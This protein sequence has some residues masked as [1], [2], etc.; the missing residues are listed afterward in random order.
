MEWGPAR[1]GISTAVLGHYSS[2]TYSSESGNL[3]LYCSEM[4]EL[5]ASIIAE[6]VVYR[7]AR[8]KEDE[9]IELPVQ[10]TPYWN[11]VY[12][13][14]FLPTPT[15]SAVCICLNSLVFHFAGSS[16]YLQLLQLCLL[17]RWN[18][19]NDDIRLCLCVYIYYM[20]LPLAQSMSVGSHRSV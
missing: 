4:I 14:G 8:K 16:M 20:A 7:R 1:T 19:K 9:G 11:I 12:W 2:K 6:E 18:L 13:R 10:C 3:Y 17:S 5:L 15:G